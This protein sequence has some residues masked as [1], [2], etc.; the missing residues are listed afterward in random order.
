M[1]KELSKYDC[2]LLVPTISYEWEFSYFVW[3]PNSH[4]T[5][6]KLH[7]ENLNRSLK[8]FN[9]LFLIKFHLYPKLI[10]AFEPKDIE[11]AE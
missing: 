5:K 10:I 7:I 6:T 2:P 1:I 9:Y 4:V 8:M 3:V 11:L